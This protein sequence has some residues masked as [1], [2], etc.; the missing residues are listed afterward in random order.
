ML[1]MG[2]LWN[3]LLQELNCTPASCKP[4][5]QSVSAEAYIHKHNRA[6][7]FITHNDVGK[8]QTFGIPSSK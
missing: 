5:E 2:P 6:Y 1:W 7:H 4:E 8:E 3:Y